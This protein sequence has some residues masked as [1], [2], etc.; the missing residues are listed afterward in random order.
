MINFLLTLLLLTI[1]LTP[2][3]QEQQLQIR[4]RRNWGY[5]SGTGRI[6]GTFT[7]RAS[8]PANLTQVVFYLDGLNLGEVNEA[9]FEL[10]FVTDDYPQGVHQ[11]HATGFTAD[12]LELQSNIIQTEFVTAA[13]GWQAA[14]RLIVPIVVII[15][16]AAGLAIMVPL[17]F[18]RGKKE[19]LA[20]GAP[21]HYGH[22][23]G[24]ICPKCSRPYSM[25]IYGLNLA[26]HRYDRCPFCGKWSLVRRASRDEL[27]AAEAAEI[28]AAREGKFIPERSEEDALRQEIEDS[29]FED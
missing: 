13:E 3:Q 6:Q 14:S 18:S 26:T 25:H 20:P 12:D 1:Q 5:S 21:R 2:V 7:I 19:Q 9:P 4:L 16:I 29:R 23:G 15:G 28:S 11:I 17:I 8:G 24:A 22:Y 27:E 10:R